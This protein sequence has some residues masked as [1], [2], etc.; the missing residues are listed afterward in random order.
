[1]EPRIS[2]GDVTLAA[3]FAR[4]AEVPVGRVMI[5][6]N[7]ARPQDRAPLVHRVVSANQDGTFITKGDANRDNDSTPMPREN[8]RARAVLLVPH[9]GLPLVWASTG[10][11]ALLS[12][13][14]LLTA[15]A[16]YGAGAPGRSRRRHNRPINPPGGAGSTVPPP[17]S[18]YRPRLPRLPAALGSASVA[19]AIA[20]TAS[21]AGPAMA[22]FSAT[23]RNPGNSWSVASIPSLY[24]TAVLA[25]SP[26][27]YYRLQETSGP[28]MADSSGNGRTGTY[29]AVGAYHQAGALTGL[30][31]YAVGLA[32]ATGRLI[33]GGPAW[34]D[35]NTF[36]LE[37]WIKTSTT[38]G[39][40][41]IGFESTQGATSPTFD[42]HLF[43]RPDG[44]IVYEGGAGQQQITTPLAYNNGQWH[45][46]VLA[47]SQHGAFQDAAIYVDGLQKVSGS[48]AKTTFYSGWWRVGYGSL[49]TGT[50]YPASANFTGSVDEVAIYPTA[51]TTLRIAAHYAA[52]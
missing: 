20:V 42:R 40:K 13:W 37:L 11:H 29:A 26:R 28:A 1:M 5:M 39:G 38:T 16:F 12:A 49:P 9:V 52:R 50:G 46:L 31:N 34:S 6:T 45:H 35:P 48:T 41:L 25:D 18:R 14:V 32:G 4:D 47:A 8:I 27:A 2:T 33:S 51:L 30:S 36:T 15:A 3:P 17:R 44:K 43:M 7:P 23:T 24:Q 22:A 21:S 10:S 19:V